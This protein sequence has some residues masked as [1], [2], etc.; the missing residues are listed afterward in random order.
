MKKTFKFAAIAI[1]AMAL[2]TA[3][4]NAPETTEDTTAIDTPEVIDTPVVDTIVADTVAVV[5]ETPATTAKKSNKKTS[6]KKAVT[7]TKT[8]GG[9]VIGAINT[10]EKTTKQE[11]AITNGEFKR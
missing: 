9:K 5:E 3:C 2:M 6:N 8:E 10:T 7:E 11:K 4:N 1:A